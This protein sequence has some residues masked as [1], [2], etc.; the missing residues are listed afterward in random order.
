MNVNDV[1]AGLSPA[2]ALQT[3]TRNPAEYLD[4]LKDLGTVERGKL[5]DLVLFEADPLA[6][7]RNVRKIHAVIV[8]GKLL[9]KATVEKLAE[10][11]KP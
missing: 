6:D 5:A 1:Q 3:A 8:A 11:R 4:R 10:G 9:P 2:E 7:I